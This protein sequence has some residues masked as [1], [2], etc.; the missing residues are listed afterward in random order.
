MF[1]NKSTEMPDDERRDNVLKNV[2]DLAKPH[3]D[4]MSR[5]QRD[6]LIKTITDMGKP[7]ERK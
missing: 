7:P 5:E 6:A 4:N 1:D 3:T 2:L